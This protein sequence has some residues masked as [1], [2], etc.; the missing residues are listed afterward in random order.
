MGLDIDDSI[1]NKFAEF[2]IFFKIHFD[3][4]IKLDPLRLGDVM[5]A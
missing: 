1:L 4:L 5:P 2:S 3:R